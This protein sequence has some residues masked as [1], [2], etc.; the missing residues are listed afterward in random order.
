MFLLLILVF[1]DKVWIAG[2]RS[3]SAPS[4]NFDFL[5]FMT[6]ESQQLQWK[7]EGLS[8]DSLSLENAVVML[9]STQA[10]YFIDPSST[11]T[12]WLKTH[13][14]EK[15]L[16]VVNHQVSDVTNFSVMT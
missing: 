5:T 10:C 13:L 9:R 3:S 7:L 16:E 12:D 11:A 8:F 14:K 4:F 15:R 1:Y 2:V 6:T